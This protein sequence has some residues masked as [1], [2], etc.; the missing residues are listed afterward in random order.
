[1]S[2][3]QDKENNL[4]NKSRTKMKDWIHQMEMIY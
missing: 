1:M 4:A 3:L 2:T